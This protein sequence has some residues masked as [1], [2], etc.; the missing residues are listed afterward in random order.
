MRIHDGAFYAASLFLLGIAAASLGV[1]FPVVVAAWAGLAGIF[2]FSPNLIFIKPHSR[3]VLVS[4]SF[5]FLLGWVYFNLFY[6]AK[7]EVLPAGDAVFRGVVIEEPL[8]GERSQEILLRLSDPYAGEVRVYAPRYPE[9]HY[10]NLMSAEGEVR[11]SPSGALNISGFP[12]IKLVA[13][14]GGSAV[15][16][17]LLKFKNSFLEN[18]K[19]VLPDEEAALAGGLTVGERASFSDEFKDAMAKSGTTHI[20]A[21]SGYNISII[22][23]AISFLLAA[24]VSRGK[25]FYISVLV[26]IL[27][28]IMTGAEASV[29]RA[30]IMGILVLFAE[31]TGR[32]YSMRN[33]L[34][35]AA[36]VMALVNPKVLVFNVGFQL[37][38]GAL[39]G[40][41]Y[42]KP[43]I[44]KIFRLGD[45]VGFLGWKANA[46]TSLSAQLAV[47]PV[48]LYNFGSINLLSVVANVLIL[49]ILPFAMA[50]GFAAGFTGFISYQ[51][52]LFTGLLTRP[53]L[54]WQIWVISFFGRISIPLAWDNFPPFLGAVYYLLIVAL[55]VWSRRAPEPW[56][57]RPLAS[58]L[59]LS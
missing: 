31:R 25:A 54:L 37:S 50:L 40:I 58:R 1:S 19:R 27:F 55:I 33:A 39:L 44:E 45:G 35:L 12:Q 32:L 46:L 2:A 59:P 16:L 48:L 26:I 56:E 5:I 23:F 42:L 36:F 15:K 57:P 22:G 28:V 43:A 8:H 52:S 53:L 4:L 41:V 7:E 20:V 21:L 13:E 11:K 18:I 3:V 51:L 6:I 49:E 47:L 9:F 24:F 17:A 34:V 10:G 30:A 29:V 14:D 38:F